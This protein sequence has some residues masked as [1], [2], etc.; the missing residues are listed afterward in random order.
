MFFGVKFDCHDLF[1]M[2]AMIAMIFWGW[3]GEKIAGNSYLNKSMCVYM[4][5]YVCC[6]GGVCCVSKI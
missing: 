2:I 1:A 4:C 5:A 3:F 6:M